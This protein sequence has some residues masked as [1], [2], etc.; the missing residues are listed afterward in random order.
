L[1]PHS[2]KEMDKLEYPKLKLRAIKLRKKG[3]SYGE[4]KKHIPVSKSTLSLWLKSVPLTDGQKNRLYTK[5]ILFLARGPQSQR[6]RRAR[7]I[8]GILNG[9]KREIHIPL[10]LE[11]YKLL[12]AF[13]YWAEGDKTV[14]FKIT[15]S[16]PSLILFMVRWLKKIF[17]IPPS[18]LKA[19]LNIYTQ[20]NEEEIKGFWSQLTGIPIDNFGKSFVKPNSKNYKKNNLYY[21][22]ISVRAP[23]GTNMRHKIFGWVQASLKNIDDDVI[24]TQKEWKS[25]KDTARPAN[26]P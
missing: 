5:N 22:T 14:G 8:M 9:A 19:W 25:L 26:I 11:T 13:L 4:I 6:E 23:K 3:L 10:S 20:Q 24:L 12:G 17:E 7:E 2:L 1:R 21:G 15:N 16:D 18:E